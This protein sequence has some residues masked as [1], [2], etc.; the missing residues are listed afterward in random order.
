LSTGLLRCFALKGGAA[1]LLEPVLVDE[2]ALPHAEGSYRRQLLAPIRMEPGATARLDVRLFS[3]TP[4]IGL[5]WEMKA[6]LWGE[7]QALASTGRFRLILSK[8]KEHDN[9]K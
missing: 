6:T 4:G 7:G 3:E 1:E 8:S 5:G 9:A 2:H